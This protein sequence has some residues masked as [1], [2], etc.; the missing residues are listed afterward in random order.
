[1]F[2]TNLNQIEYYKTTNPWFNQWKDRM[3][4][5]HGDIPPSS[6]LKIWENLFSSWDLHPEQPEL[7]AAEEMGP[8]IDPLFTEE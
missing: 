2:I 4:R 6:A 3:P 7:E 5:N 1:M 8:Y